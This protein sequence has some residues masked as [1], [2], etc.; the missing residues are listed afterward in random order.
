MRSVLFWFA[1]LACVLL[2]ACAPSLVHGADEHD[3]GLA[4]ASAE[5]RVAE[6]YNFALDAERA[7]ANVSELLRIMN[8]AGD[9][10]SKAELA[11]GVGDYDGAGVYAAQCEGRLAGFEVQANALR[12][13]ASWQRQLD[14]MVNV[15][16]SAAGTVAVLVGGWLV[17]RYL[18]KKHAVAGGAAA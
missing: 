18:K 9:L 17:W 7:G 2:V 13:S 15:V 10:L 6:C 16:G 11:F 3:A 14:L 12:D 8:E 1:G 4:V 5:L